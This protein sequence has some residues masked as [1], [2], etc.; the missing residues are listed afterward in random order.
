MVGSQGRLAALVGCLAL[1]ACGE[2]PPHVTVIVQTPEAAGAPGSAGGVGAGV[3][4]ESSEPDGQAGEGPRAEVCEG[5]G[6]DPDADDWCSVYDNCPS[7]SNPEQSDL[8]QNGVGDICDQETC[9]GLDDDGNGQVDDG[10]PDD[11]DD[12]V[13]DCLD[14]C[15]NEPDLDTDNDGL[16]NCLDGCPEDPA[17]DDDDDGIC[18]STDNCR[19]TANASQSDK[20]A[21]GVGDACDAEIC[22]GIDND[23]DFGIDEGMTDSDDDDICDEVDT[24]PEDPLNDADQD[25]HCAADDNCAGVTNVVQEDSDDDRLGDACDFDSAVA[26]GSSAPLVSEPIPSKFLPQQMVVD[27]TRNL[28]YVTI[29]N[30]FEAPYANHLV[31]LDP[32]TGQIVWSLLV[33]SG[34]RP[35]AVTADGSRAYVGLDAIGQVRVVDLERRSACFMFSLGSSSGD[36]ARYAY[37]M[38]VLPS[39]P[40]TVV[41]SNKF[42][43]TTA[44][45][46][47]F[48][49]DNGA[50][51]RDNVTSDTYL[52]AGAGDGL[53]YGYNNYST[54]F[55]LYEIQIDAQGARVVWTQQDLLSGF[56]ADMLYAGGRIY[57]TTGVVLDPTVPQLVGKFATSGALTVDGARSEAYVL[58]AS[59]RIDV[60]DTITFQLKRSLTIPSLGGSAWQIA[61]VGAA[62]LV[63]R[64]GGAGGLAFTQIE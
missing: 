44:Y 31:A 16:A 60:Y 52:L 49:F 34:P 18:G 14:R 4:G 43:G 3:G 25:G 55:G 51:R 37:S 29:G 7:V 17:N 20:D 42:Q 45:G 36:G 1:L 62:G 12:T 53:V 64:H 24:C 50:P 32:T 47:L 23:G 63:I 48:V 28:V 57:S 13:A 58:A 26:C 61:R 39:R 8:N 30:V 41:I 6:G 54:A 21:D 5:L 22:D 11:D 56:T 33:G 9:N 46:G 59:T 15:P 35:I 38:A 19:I 27:E 40:E 10:Y 2:E